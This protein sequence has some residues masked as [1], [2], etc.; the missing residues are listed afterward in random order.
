MNMWHLASSNGGR[1]GWQPL[2]GITIEQAKGMVAERTGLDMAE[3]FDLIRTH[4]RSRR[5]RLTQ[6]ASEIVEG[7]LSLEEIIGKG[8][9]TS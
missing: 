9:P 5:R 3:S 7:T 6:V 1:F 4:A 2:P 8:A